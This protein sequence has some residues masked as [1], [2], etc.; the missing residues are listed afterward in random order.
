M[1]EDEKKKEER[2][3]EGE[4]RTKG[5]VSNHERQFITMAGKMSLLISALVTA[6]KS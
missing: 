5:V 1:R 2:K 3:E 4:G 6:T